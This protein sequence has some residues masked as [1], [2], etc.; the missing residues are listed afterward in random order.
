MASF[1]N[2]RLQQ[3]RDVFAAIS[4]QTF[5]DNVH[6]VHPRSHLLNPIQGRFSP[7]LFIPS[8]CFASSEASYLK[9]HA[10]CQPGS[11]LT[12]SPPDCFGIYIS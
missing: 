2:C 5:V 8:G 1:A 7:S 11:V 3:S 6:N 12:F 9:V 4:S 10:N